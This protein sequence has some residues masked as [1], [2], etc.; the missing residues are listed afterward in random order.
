MFKLN[1]DAI[2]LEKT[3]VVKCLQKG[4]GLPQKKKKFKKYT[5][6]NQM[7]IYWVQMRDEFLYIN[8]I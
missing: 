8:K 6:W 2:P 4:E 7:P 1:A 5:K 3:S